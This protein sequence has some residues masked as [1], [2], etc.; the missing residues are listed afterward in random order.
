MGN[1]VYDERRRHRAEFD[2][3]QVPVLDIGTDVLTE[4]LDIL[5]WLSRNQPALMPE[6]HQEDILAQ[7]E[8]FYG[9]HAQPLAAKSEALSWGIPNKALEMLEDPEISDTYRRSLEIRSIL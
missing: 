5:H 3:P 6:E 8:A 7:L 1:W 4:S 2:S 9:F